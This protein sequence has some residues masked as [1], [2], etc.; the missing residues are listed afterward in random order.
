MVKGIV[1]NLPPEIAARIE[2][3]LGGA[4]DDDDEQRKPGPVP[5]AKAME[6]RLRHRLAHEPSDIKPGDI[7]REKHG[8]GATKQ[9]Y[10]AEQVMIVW[11]LLDPRDWLDRQLV[12]K[13]IERN[14]AGV[15]RPDCIVAELGNGGEYV[16]LHPHQLSMLERLAVEGDSSA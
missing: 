5:L 14:I 11:R 10:R 3:A 1:T 6:L 15:D 13:W 16:S 9:E 2:R 7:V 4:L 8:L 12:E